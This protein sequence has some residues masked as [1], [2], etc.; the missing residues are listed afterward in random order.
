[1]GKASAIRWAV[2]TIIDRAGLV[3]RLLRAVR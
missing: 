2:G 1:M 3:G